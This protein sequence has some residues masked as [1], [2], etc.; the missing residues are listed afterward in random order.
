MLAVLHASQLVTMAGPN[1]ARSGTELRE[2]GI[3]NDGALLIDGGKIAAVGT[4][5]EVAALA[6]DGE[7]IDAGGKVVLPGFVDAHT[8]LVFAGERLDDFEARARG[9]SY[10]QIARRGGGIQTTVKATRA[11]NEPELFAL[12]KKRASWFLRN[13]TTTVEAKSGYGLS[14]ED[15]MKILRVIRRVG[16]ETPLETVATF[17]GAHAVPA[18]SDREQY[19]SLVI[20]KMLPRIAGEGLAEFCDI[21]CERNYVDLASSRRILEAAKR[22]GL[23][24]RMH[25]DQLTNG[26][27]AKLAAEL[28]AATAD[29]LEQSDADG[30][31]ALAKAAV[32]PVL[33]PGSVYALGRTKYPDSRAMIEAGLA[34]VLA[35]DFNPGSSPTCSMPMVMSLAVTQMNMSPAEALTAATINAAASLGRAEEIGSLEAG[36]VA[37][38]VIFDC[39]D[40]REIAYWF[41]ISLVSEVFVRGQRICATSS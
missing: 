22:R 9:E 12:A 27:G 29:H 18:G 37:N 6:K 41:G 14:V 19:I 23:K 32:Q 20:D 33:L 31:A 28:R 40:Y 17:L 24:L 3:L 35:S 38:F 15:E 13:G 36:K 25:V 26:G 34:V 1:R 39:K 7:I 5:A 30:I 21:F 16:A 2:L 8:H 11:A 4:S 10:E